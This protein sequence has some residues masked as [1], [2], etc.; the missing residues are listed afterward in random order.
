MVV[1]VPDEPEKIVHTKPDEILSFKLSRE[2]D[3]I[4]ANYELEMDS[5]INQ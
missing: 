3:E 4:M 1:K 5:E 2:L